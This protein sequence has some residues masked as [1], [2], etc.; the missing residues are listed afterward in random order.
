M[1]WAEYLESMPWVKGEKKQWS[2]TIKLILAFIVGLVALT[3]AILG[4]YWE[5][6]LPK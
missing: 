6:V 5:W 4:L 3:P 1:N 2:P